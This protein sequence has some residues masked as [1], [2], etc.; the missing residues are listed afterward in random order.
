MNI[1]KVSYY[2]EEDFNTIQKVFLS[3]D[4]P[5][6]SSGNRMIPFDEGESF[7]YILIATTSNKICMCLNNN[8]DDCDIYTLDVRELL[9]LD[10]QQL[11]FDYLL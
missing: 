8:P 4:I 3:H 9:S 5:W 11:L 6:V 10:L 1:L 7:E 2:D